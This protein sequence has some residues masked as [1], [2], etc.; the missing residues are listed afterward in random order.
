MSQLIARAF[1]QYRAACATPV[2]LLGGEFL[3]RNAEDALASQRHADMP[4]R[5]RDCLLAPQV[6]A[7]L[8]QGGAQCG[9]LM[10]FPYIH[11]TIGFDGKVRV[12]SRPE[13]R[14]RMAALSLVWFMRFM[15]W[16]LVKSHFY[17][18]SYLIPVGNPCETVTHSLYESG[19]LRV[20]SS[21][22]RHWQH[23][24]GCHRG[25]CSRD[26][27]FCPPGL[28]FL[29]SGERISAGTRAPPARAS[30]A[31]ARRFPGPLSVTGASWARSSLA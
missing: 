13:H 6:S 8:L 7:R 2:R 10:P 17:V 29:R 30:C 14:F 9:N 3:R 12:T 19:N 22:L 15:D 5:E 18:R 1:R 27:S 31:R 28:S 26:G 16:D 4:G 20:D 25:I 21:L 23:S 11:L 24:L